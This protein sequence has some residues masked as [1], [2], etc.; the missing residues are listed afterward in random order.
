[1]LGNERP[2]YDRWAFYVACLELALQ[3]AIWLHG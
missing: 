3:A 2:D 1:M